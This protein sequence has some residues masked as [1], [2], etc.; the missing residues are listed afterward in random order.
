MVE[1]WTVIAY[2][3]AGGLRAAFVTT[4]NTDATCDLLSN[5]ARGV[6]DDSVCPILMGDVSLT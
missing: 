2:E 6:L 3:V 1:S 4:L 5:F